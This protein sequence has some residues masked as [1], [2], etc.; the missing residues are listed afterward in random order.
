MN[1]PYRTPAPM[2]VVAP[3]PV[4]LHHGPREKC[5]ACGVAVLKYE[6]AV[7]T[8]ACRGASWLLRFFGG[9]R[10]VGLGLHLHQRCRACGATWDCDPLEAA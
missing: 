8:R 1:A 2:P 9:C 3:D 4:K 5:A 6:K 10:M 7:V